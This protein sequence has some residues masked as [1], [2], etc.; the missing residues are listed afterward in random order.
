MSAMALLE[1]HRAMNQYEQ[2]ATEVIHRQQRAMQQYEQA[3]RQQQEA[4]QQYKQAAKQSQELR[5]NDVRTASDQG[6]FGTTTAATNQGGRLHTNAEGTRRMIEIDYGYVR[7]LEEQAG[8]RGANPE[9]MIELGSRVAETGGDP[10]SIASLDGLSLSESQM[11]ALEGIFDRGGGS[12]L[13]VSQRS[14]QLD[15]SGR[16]RLS[17]MDEMEGISL[18]SGNASIGEISEFGMHR[19]KRSSSGI[20]LPSGASLGDISEFGMSFGMS[21]SR[22]SGG[23]SLGSDAI[24]EELRRRRGGDVSMAGGSS[25]SGSHDSI[26]SKRMKADRNDRHVSF[27]ATKHTPRENEAASVLQSLSDA[28]YRSPLF[29]SQPTPAAAPVI[30]EKYAELS[31]ERRRKNQSLS[32]YYK[33]TRGPSAMDEG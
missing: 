14:H 33:S 5:S 12:A 11:R 9:A 6:M 15:T 25:S 13:S 4:L 30:T 22:R 7:R 16:S 8:I 19:S 27:D 23:G 29:G 17:L 1:Q 2:R 24:L 31:E 18:P 28:S 3:S 20:S 26:F 32:A 10:K 21:R